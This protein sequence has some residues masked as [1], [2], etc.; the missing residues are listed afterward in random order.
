MDETEGQAGGH[1]DE[2]FETRF[3]FFGDDRHAE[4]NEISSGRRDLAFEDVFALESGSQGFDRDIAVVFEIL[5]DVFAFFRTVS[6]RFIHGFELEQEFGTAV[7]VDS[8][9]DGPG[10]EFSGMSDDIAVVRE[11]LILHDPGLDE[12]R[13]EKTFFAGGFFDRGR[14]IHAFVCGLFLF[15]KRN[16]FRQ[17]RVG[18]IRHH[19]FEGFVEIALSERIHRE[20]ENGEDDQRENAAKQNRFFIHFFSAAAVSG[21]MTEPIAF[22]VVSI[23][24]LSAILIR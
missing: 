4:R 13:K 14:S 1:L 10:G 11:F 18:G 8:E 5:L 15:G 20:D 6:T 17:F 21:V 12:L 2:F 24:T 3:F 22:F 16:D 9:T 7:E 23:L 19:G